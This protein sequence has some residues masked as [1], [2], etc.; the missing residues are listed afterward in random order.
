[1]DEYSSVVVFSSRPVLHLS[2]VVAEML[3]LAQ[4]KTLER[5]A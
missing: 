2:L 5:N 3:A 1:M 4:G